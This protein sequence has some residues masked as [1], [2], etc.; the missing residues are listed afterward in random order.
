[1]KQHNTGKQVE[2]TDSVIEYTGTIKEGGI[3]SG[4]WKIVEGGGKGCNGNFQM[5]GS[6]QDWK[7]PKTSKLEPMCLNLIV[8]DDFVYGVSVDKKGM[9]LVQG[10][11]DVETEKVEFIQ[12]YLWKGETYRFQGKVERKNK[13]KKK[14]IVKITGWYGKNKEECTDGEFHLEGCWGQLGVTADP[15]AKLKKKATFEADYLKESQVVEPK[16]KKPKVNWAGRYEQFDQWHPMNFDDMQYGAK[17]GVVVG[18]GKDDV[19]GFE[20]SG[21]LDLK[22]SHIKFRKQYIGQHYVDYEG[23]MDA[24][25]DILGTYEIEDEMGDG[26]F[27]L[28]KKMQYGMFNYALPRAIG[29]SGGVAAE[30]WGKK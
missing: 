24:K 30:E 16:P 29:K 10:V 21:N 28:K 15:K 6:S 22:T 26:K 7:T 3:L 18:S 19:G 14:S 4:K 13:T 25:G 17:D 1:M 2:A 5:K 12:K 9:Y 11:N 8:D 23:D 20:I 27:E